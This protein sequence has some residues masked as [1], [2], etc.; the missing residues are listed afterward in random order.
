MNSLRLLVL[1]ATVFSSL[2]AGTSPFVSI[3]LAGELPQVAEIATK[4]QRPAE[5]PGLSAVC[6]SSRWI[7]PRNAQ[8]PWDTFKVAATFHATDYVWTYSLDPEAVGRMKQSGG[9]VYLAIN[10]LV[11][12]EPGKSERLRGRILELDGNRVTAPWMRGWK[13]SYWGCANSPQ[14]RESYVAYAKRAVDAGTDGLQMDDPPMNVAAVR[15]GGCFCPHCMAGFRKYLKSQATTADLANWEIDSVERFDYREYLKARKAPVGDAFAGYDGG[16]LK[17][18]FA[19]FQEQSVRAFYRDV[20][21]EIDKHAGRHVV[22]SSNNYAGRWQF[23]YDL[24]EF[25]MAE[26]PERDAVPKTIYERFADARVRGKAQLF[27]LVPKAADGSEAA[28]TRR[29]IAMS[30]ACGGHVIVPWDVYTGSNSPRYYGNPEHYADLYK[31]VRDHSQ[32]FDG[33]EDAAFLLPGLTDDRYRNEPPISLSDTGDVAA[34]TRAV[35][36]K[37]EAPVVVHVV[38]WRA[39]PKPITVKLRSRRFFARGS[40]RAELLRPGRPTTRLACGTTDTHTSIEIPPLGP[41]GIVVLKPA[42]E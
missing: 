3:G 23:P 7:H 17:R 33:Y 14:Y 2:S 28:L 18:L 25:G 27:T 20:R 4:A 30:Y 37:P 32:F 6:F 19:A 13:G 12:D 41:W 22:F 26:L 5:A 42:G 15:W 10:S 16:P 8:D 36:G 34:I 1:G 40:L 29:V 9:N 39:D 35:P 38:D 21:S 11:P 24:F 31:F